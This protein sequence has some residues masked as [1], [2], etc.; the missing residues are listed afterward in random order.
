MKNANPAVAVVKLKARASVELTASLDHDQVIADSRHAEAAWAIDQGYRSCLDLYENLIGLEEV[1][2]PEA[3]TAWLQDEA[4]TR[5]LKTSLRAFRSL[6]SICAKL[7]IDRYG[8][9]VNSKKVEQLIALTTA[10]LKGVTVFDPKAHADA[11]A[12]AERGETTTLDELRKR[13]SDRRP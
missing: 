5:L 4:R 3:R 7:E 1:L 10:M 11:L 13:L 12:E 8:H 9:E 6:S 2:S